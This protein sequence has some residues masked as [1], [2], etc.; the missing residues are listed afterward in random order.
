[1]KL[2]ELNDL[3]P[4][5]HHVSVAIREGFCAVVVRTEAPCRIVADADGFTHESA[6]EI[7]PSDSTIVAC[8]SGVRLDETVAACAE[9]LALQATQP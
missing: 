3:V 8:A 5:T 4:P 1:M 9:V 2:S 7:M 6:H